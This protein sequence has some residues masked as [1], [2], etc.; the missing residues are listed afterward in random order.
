MGQRCE[1][2]WYKPW[3]VKELNVPPDMRAQNPH[4]LVLGAG[5]KGKTRLIASWVMHDIMAND[6]AVIA[7]DSDGALIDLLTRHIAANPKGKELAKR[8]VLIDPTNKTGS[9]SY[10][11]LEMPDDGDLQSAASSVVFGFKAIYCRAAWLAKSVESTNS[12]RLA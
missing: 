3:Q 4:I 7:I 5:D 12:Q 1:W 6:R 2:R 11:P 8:I 9:L 10:N